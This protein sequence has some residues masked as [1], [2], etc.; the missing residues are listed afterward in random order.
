LA[1]VVL[2]FYAFSG[3]T[4]SAKTI[5]FSIAVEKGAEMASIQLKAKDGG[6]GQDGGETSY[7]RQGE[8]LESSERCRKYSRGRRS[9]GACR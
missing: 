6:W 4:T 7:V 9:V 5:L 1:T 2:A 3:N 8:H